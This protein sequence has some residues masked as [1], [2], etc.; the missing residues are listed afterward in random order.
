MNWIAAWKVGGYRHQIEDGL[1]RSLG[2]AQRDKVPRVREAFAKEATIE[3]FA[4]LSYD[5][6]GMIVGSTGARRLLCVANSAA[7]V[8]IFGLEI[9]MKNINA[10]LEAALA[11]VVRCDTHP[12]SQTVGRV[13]GHAHWV[14]EH[15]ML[16]TAPLAF[17]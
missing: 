10:V 15:S 11:C 4:F 16:E 13:F 3:T 6:G 7:I 2:P 9:E 1:L 5:E 17:E 14:R 8:V 12:G